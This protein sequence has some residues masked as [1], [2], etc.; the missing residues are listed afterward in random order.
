MFTTFTLANAKAGSKIRKS[1]PRTT[2][3]LF[4]PTIACSMPIY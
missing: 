4:D 3:D 1:C 2:F